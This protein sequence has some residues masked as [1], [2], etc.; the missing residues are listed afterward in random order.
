MVIKMDKLHRKLVRH[1][2]KGNYE[3]VERL[4]D[5]GVD[6]NF[7]G[8]PLQLSAANGH[9]HIVH[10]LG[11]HNVDFYNDGPLALQMSAANGHL[12]VVKNLTELK[13]GGINK[14]LQM[15]ARNGHLNVVEYLESIGANIHDNNDQA[16]LCAAENGHLEI[17]RYLMNLGSNNDYLLEVSAKKGHLHVVKFLVN[18][19]FS[20][21]VDDYAPLCKSVLYGHL[22]VVKYL[23]RKGSNVD[24]LNYCLEL[25]A[26]DG[27][28]EIVKYLIKKGANIHATDN[29]AL[30]SAVEYDQ[31][32]IVKYLIKKGA[33][34]YSDTHYALLTSA[35]LD[36][37]DIFTLLL[38]LYLEDELINAIKH[39]K[40]N[41]LLK[42]ASRN[43]PSKY[44]KL[45]K[46]FLESGIDIYDMMD[47]ELL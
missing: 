37:L 20:V 21:N 8:E 12:D 42:C 38:S 15:S 3:E 39:D 36:Y 19:N 13:I 22:D 25:S 45:M 10:L 9:L 41:T 40:Y 7:N 11:D 26:S 46:A 47:K 16:L 44:P 6:I 4:I 43:G 23:I 1:A 33:N 18:N 17:V 32:K 2:K 28:F 14:A 35:D 5:L 29:Q 31:Y 34:I 30:S 27:Y 24:V